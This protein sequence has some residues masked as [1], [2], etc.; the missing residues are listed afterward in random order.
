VADLGKRAIEAFA[1]GARSFAA[2]GVFLDSVSDAVVIIGPDGRV[3]LAN[4]EAERLFGFSRSELVGLPVE[5]LVPERFREA[6]ARYR[7]DYGSDPRSRAMGAGLELHGRRK[8]GTEFPVDISLSP[9]GT[10]EGLLFAATIRLIT[11]GEALSPF[12][13]FL[14]WAPDAVVIVDSDGRVAGVNA[15]TERLFGF[16]R[17]ELVGLPV[18]QLV[19][20]RFREAHV[21][22]RVRYRSEPRFRPLGAGLEL[23]GRRKDG[24]EF[25]VDI[26]LS[27]F[28]SG[29]GVFFA[30]AIRDVRER[31]PSGRSRRERAPFCWAPSFTCRRYQPRWCPVPAW[32]S[33]SMTPRPER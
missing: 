27:R 17:S 24:T 2:V 26:S 20:E 10:E 30:A 16:S 15:R 5:Q 14:E 4:A 9:L 28:E 31:W 13:A 18:E 12:S 6:H 19:P 1:E 7:A 11:D 23:Y 32:S 33:C 25:P 22:H 29:E 8:D 3:V 21:A